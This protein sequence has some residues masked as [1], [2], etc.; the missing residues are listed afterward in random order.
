MKIMDAVCILIILLY[1]VLGFK[2][3]V[4]KSGVQLIGTIAVLIIS[5]SL[6]NILANFLMKTL[7]FYNFPGIFQGISAMNILIYE[8]IS[9][10]VIFVL[11]YCVL[12]ILLTASGLIEKLLKATI[13]LAIPSKILGAVVGLVEGLIMT[14]L[15]VLILY[16]IPATESLIHESRVSRIILERTPIIAN[17]SAGTTQA[18]QEIMDILEEAETKESTED[19]EYIN[20]EVMNILIKYKVITAEEAQELV[21]SDKIQTTSEYKFV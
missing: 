10:I 14:F 16:H 4:I 15:I 9:F 13:V 19:R 11:L 7:P 17:V 6:K 20:F 2:R 12:N 3:G 21:D 8:L 5:F 18:L 1:V